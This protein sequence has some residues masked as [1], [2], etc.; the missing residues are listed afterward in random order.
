[1]EG[2]PL[3]RGGQEHSDGKNRGGETMVVQVEPRATVPRLNIHAR[4]ELSR[5]HVVITCLIVEPTEV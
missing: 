1:M 5:D 3:R 4:A 2:V